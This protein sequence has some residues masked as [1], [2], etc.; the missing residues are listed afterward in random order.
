MAVSAVEN[1]LI[2]IIRKKHDRLYRKEFTRF[3]LGQ[4][5]QVFDENQYKAKKYASIKKLLPVKHKPLLLLLN[6]YRIFSIHPKGEVVTAQIAESILHL[7]FTFM[8]DK[9][10]CPYTSAELKCV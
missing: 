1:R 8:F 5:I 6:Q 3:T 9:A 4:L 2:E 10:T 7:S